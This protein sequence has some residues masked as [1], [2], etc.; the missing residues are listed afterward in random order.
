MREKIVLRGRAVPTLVN[1][2]NGASFVARYEMI[3]RKE[4]TRA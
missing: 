2:P 1:L 3:S 4:L